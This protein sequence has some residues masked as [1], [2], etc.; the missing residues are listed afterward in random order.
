MPYTRR[1]FGKLA[2]AATP[3]AETLG[4]NPMQV[5]ARVAELKKNGRLQ[6]RDG[7]LWVS[8]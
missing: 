3:L 8:A 7:V 1:D 6:E 2:M 5:R 4:A